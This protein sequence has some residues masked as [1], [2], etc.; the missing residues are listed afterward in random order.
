MKNISLVKYIRQSVEDEY[1]MSVLYHC[2]K[3]KFLDIDF[4]S[5]DMDRFVLDGRFH[6]EPICLSFRTRYKTPCYSLSLL[7]SLRVLMCNKKYVSLCEDDNLI[8][9]SK[10]I[11]S[12]Q[13][14][15]FTTFI[16]DNW[17]DDEIKMLY[18]MMESAYFDEVLSEDEIRDFRNS[19]TIPEFRNEELY[20]RNLS[21]QTKG[22]GDEVIGNN[23]FVD[24]D[25]EKFVIHKDIE[26]VGNTAFAFCKK[27]HTLVFEGKS[28]FGTF[29]IIECPN[30]SQIVVPE[31]YVDYYKKAIPFYR[32]IICTEEIV[33]KE[34]A[35]GKKRPRIGEKAETSNLAAIP[36][37]EDKLDEVLVNTTSKD[38]AVKNELV[39]ES[40]PEKQEGT[41][42]IQDD[43]TPFDPKMLEKVFDKKVTSYKYLWMLAILTLTKEHGILAISFKDLTIRMAGFAWPLL[44]D[45]DIDFGNTDF[46]KK[47]LTEVMKKTSLIPSASQKVVESYMRQYYDS[48]GI[49]KILAPLMKNVPYRFLSP[50]IK[51]STTE[52]VVAKTNTKGY[53][54]LYAIH[55]DGILLDED[56]WEYID[57][58]YDKVYSFAFNSL[59]EYVSQYNNPMKLIKLKMR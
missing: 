44:F 20:Y 21:A 55:K 12:F 56:W 24:V 22:V 32:G 28:R 26:Y 10:P 8:F 39:V 19:I 35:K 4:A 46:M 31:E 38:Y 37:K 30:L 45:D 23:A 11:D 7:L 5:R 6:G 43:Y 16:M 41:P 2:L 13:W 59:I 53:N 34:E 25:I 51:F 1:A 14:I 49:S 50:W 40:G 17:D 27:L 48:Q 29:S 57:K 18:S 9:L 58:N 15:A 36:T 54:G 33:L 42:V 47:Y 3:K 52:D